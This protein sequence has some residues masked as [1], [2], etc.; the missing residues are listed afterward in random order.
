MFR[1]NR[2]AL[3]CAAVALAA[4]NLSGEARG[5]DRPCRDVVRDLAR[6]SGKGGGNAGGN[7]GMGRDCRKEG[8]AATKSCVGGVSG[9][10]VGCAVACAGGVKSGNF[11]PCA[12]TCGIALP[13]TGAA[14][15][16][17]MKALGRCLEDK[18]GGT[19]ERPGPPAAGN[20]GQT[21]REPRERWVR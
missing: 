6:D 9:A 21:P 10:T 5:G 15:W 7:S 11:G 13:A 16:A 19:S 17:D 8:W 4:V 1:F 14:C 12:L 3:W 2:S 18:A 20:P